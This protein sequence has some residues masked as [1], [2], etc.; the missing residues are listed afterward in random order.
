MNRELI[1]LIGLVMNVLCAML[2]VLVMAGCSRAGAWDLIAEQQEGSRQFDEDAGYAPASEK[3]VA[4]GTDGLPTISL[5]W[6]RP[7]ETVTG[8]RVYRS[9]TSDAYGAPLA[10]LDTT[11]QENSYTDSTV[12]FDVSYYYFIEALSSTT[13]THISIEVSASARDGAVVDSSFVY[14]DPAAAGG[15][16][17]SFDAPFN[18]ISGGLLGVDAGGTVLLLDG[19]YLQSSTVT[20]DKP[21]I[22]RTKTSSYHYGGAVLHG[23]DGDYAAFALL[24]GSDDSVVQ[25]LRVTR[26]HRSSGS[27]GVIQIGQN[28]GDHRPA[29]VQILSNHLYSNQGVG[30][31]NYGHGGHSV[32][33][34]IRGNRISDH[35]EGHAVRTYRGLVDGRFEE[36]V[37]ENVSGAAYAGINM[38]QAAGF[39]IA[40]NHFTNIEGNG[41]NL[42]A[43]TTGFT[44]SDNLVEYCSTERIDGAGIRLYGASHNTQV[45]ITGNTVRSNRAGI[46]QRDSDISGSLITITGN[47]ILSPLA[48]TGAMLIVNDAATGTLDARGNWFGSVEESYFEP[49]ISENVDYSDWLTGS[50]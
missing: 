42:G 2:S 50:P 45:I 41:M 11:S 9:E 30:I 38:D 44:I 22:I 8:Y 4:F 37:I 14:V 13:V 10:V 27:Q 21:V 39:I 3:F 32:R 48:V 49:L 17:G 36:N 6:A 46:R 15:G 47:S 31:S 33:T 23:G 1:R 12:V 16:N 34:I 24:S 35:S 7:D 5:Y 26:F 18:S 20:V 29:D 25:G 40:G 43:G 28:S 19:I